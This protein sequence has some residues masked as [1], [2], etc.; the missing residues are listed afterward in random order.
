MHI[1]RQI[2]L[3]SPIFIPYAAIVVQSFK[4]WAANPQEPLPQVR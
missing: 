4:P 3:E 1:Y 2:S